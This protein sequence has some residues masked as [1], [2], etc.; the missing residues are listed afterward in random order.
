MARR[1]SVVGWE[2]CMN[3][4]RKEGVEGAYYIFRRM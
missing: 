2:L 3:I 4:E 1:L